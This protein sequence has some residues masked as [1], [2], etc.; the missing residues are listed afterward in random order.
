MVL[1]GLAEESLRRN[2][3]LRIPLPFE[4]ALKA[5]TE[6]P[7]DKLAAPAKRKPKP[8]QKKRAKR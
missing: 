4:D 1:H 3:N 2:G 5:A 8:R 6:V 7:A